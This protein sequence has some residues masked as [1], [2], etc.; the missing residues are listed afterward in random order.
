MGGDQADSI[1]LRADH[2][3]V[4]V[5]RT[6]PI[7]CGT[8]FVDYGSQY[9]TGIYYTNPDDREIIERYVKD[10]IA[11]GYSKKIVTEIR[12]LDNYYI[13]EDYHQSYLEKNPDGY[14]HIKF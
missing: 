3:R 8:I 5:L 2:A 12:P 11:P 13:A 4:R 1:L 14:C 9:R 10:K 6:E 7:R